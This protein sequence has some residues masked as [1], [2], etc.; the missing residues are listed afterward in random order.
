M[1]KLEAGLGL[2]ANISDIERIRRILDVDQLILIGHSYGG[3]IAT[4]YAAEFPQYVKKL[5]LITPAN[6]LVM[7]PEEGGLYESIEKL[8]HDQKLKSEFKQYTKKLFDFQ[9]IFEKTDQQLAQLQLEMIRYYAIASKN[10]NPDVSMGQD[11]TKLEDI[12]G[13]PFYAFAFSTGRSANFTHT[14][15]KITMPVLILYGTQ[16]IIPI[17]SL[18]NYLKYI[19]HAQLEKVNN[20]GHFLL[21][22]KPG[23]VS[24]IIKDFLDQ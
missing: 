19:P 6:L 14:L 10:K 24:Q 18:D 20:S 16:D 8:L 23:P 3:F 15:K 22:E 4:L 12:G 21:N 7:P 2:G 9:H 13:W 11:T 17:S 5:I 1:K